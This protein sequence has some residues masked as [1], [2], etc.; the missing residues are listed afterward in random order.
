MFWPQREGAGCQ[1]W[2]W[3]E[4]YEQYLVDQKMVP[5]DYEPIFEST[6]IPHRI[7]IVGPKAKSE[8]SMN[9]EQLKLLRK[10]EMLL[11]CLFVICVLVLVSHLYAIVKSG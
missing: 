7:P 4:G 6:I 9:E 10:I 2:E 1:F 11:Q 3:E 8:E 5:Q